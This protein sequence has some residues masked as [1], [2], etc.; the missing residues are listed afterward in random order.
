[1]KKL[2]TGEFSTT[3]TWYAN[4]NWVHHYAINSLLYLRTLQEKIYKNV[5]R[6]HTATAFYTKAIWSLGKGYL[7]IYLLTPSKLQE[8]LD[9]VQIAICKYRYI[10][11]YRNLVIQFPVFIQT[12]PVPIID[13]NEQAD[14][15]THL[16]INRPYNALNSETYISI[17]QQELRTCKRIGYKFY[18]KELSV[19][20]HKSKY[21]CASVIYFNLGPD[22]VKENCN[23]AYYFNKTDVTPTV[24]DGYNEIILANWPDD[25]HIIC[26]VK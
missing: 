16:Q 7:P 21:S 23:L 13:Q 25:K 15:F 11:K 9:T 1:M 19:V 5:Q 17:R 12:V 4:K 10:Y 14:S 26:N 2:F 20:K 22:T 8:I 6:I 24:L 3:F 18:C